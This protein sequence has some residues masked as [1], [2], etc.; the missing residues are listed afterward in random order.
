MKAFN[1]DLSKVSTEDLEAELDR[2]KNET[3]IYRI[4]KRDGYDG[5]SYHRRI[6]HIIENDNGN[7]KR[8]NIMDSLGD[9]HLQ[10]KEPILSDDEPG[11]EDAWEEFEEYKANYIVGKEINITAFEPFIKADFV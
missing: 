10:M 8:L 9:M 7:V 4:V 1:M 11:Y 2:R 5:P 6:Q 3:G